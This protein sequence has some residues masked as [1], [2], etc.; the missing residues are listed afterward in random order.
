MVSPHPYMISLPR[1]TS[2]GRGWCDECPCT[3]SIPASISRCAKLDLR[4][5]D[6]VPPVRTPVHGHDRDVASTFHRQH[7][8][9]DRV[10]TAVGQVGHVCDAGSPARRRPR[11]RNAA[12]SHAARRDHDMPDD[13]RAL[14]P[15]SIQ[16]RTGALYSD[17]LERSQSVGQPLIA[18]VEDVIVGQRADIRPDRRQASDVVRMHAIVHRFA[19]CELAAGGDAGLQ[20]EQPDI[21][22]ELVDDVQRLTP[23]PREVDRRRN[24]PVR[25]LGQRDVGSRVGDKGFAQRRI[26]RVRQQLI[27]RAAGHH[28]AGEEDD[29]HGVSGC[30][31]RRGGRPI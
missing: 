11:V 22:R 27:Y 30:R 12:R 8:L 13:S 16:S 4:A 1:Y 23:R 18:E 14:G 9:G 5:V 7:P 19:R 15:L 3:T 28:V 21:R 24:G 31:P 20:I 17:V 25:L 10:G 2:M 29:R 6:V 26:A